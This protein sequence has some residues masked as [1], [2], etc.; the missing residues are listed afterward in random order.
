MTLK[1][2][3]IYLSI[4]IIIASFDACSGRKSKAEHKDIIPEEDLINILSDIYITEG[5]LS[6]PR[7]SND[8][9]KP[10]SLIP[11]INVIEKNGYTKDLMDRTMRYYFIKRPKKLIKIYDQ[12]LG[13]L[14]EMESRL[15]RSS[16]AL[17]DSGGNLWRGK[18]LYSS[19]DTL[20]H[21]TLWF[22]L[23]AGYS[24]FYTL[25]FTITLYPDDQ[26]INPRTGVFIQTVDTA[27]SKKRVYFPAIAFIKDGQPHSYNGTI[28]VNEPL[29][30]SVK[31]WFINLENQ[32]PSTERHFIIENIILSPD[33]LQ[34]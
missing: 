23:P 9:S 29:P 5:L 27:K 13:R 19:S 17:A 6:I 1:Y 28:T 7:I 4:F 11:Y 3:Y 24:R 12:V 33:K 2:I 21:D 15:V 31:G 20:N 8:F 16:P 30:L 22:E 34:E 25:K 26:T 10:D 32:A 14:S 18:S